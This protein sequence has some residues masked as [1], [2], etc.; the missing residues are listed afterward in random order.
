MLNF[1]NWLMNEGSD[2]GSKTGLYP[3]GY[4]GIG[5]YPPQWYITRSADAI[6]YL[7][8]DD[9]I[10]K[11][12]DSGQFDITH[13]PGDHNEKMNSGDGGLWDITRIRGKPSHLKKNSNFAANKGEG[14]PWKITH[15]PGKPTYTKHKDFI[16]DKGEGGIWN[17][18]NI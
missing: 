2:T 8:I 11:G 6:F 12:K 1:K 14:A 15:L 4:G 3:L 16:P 18:K 9:R 7:S 10:Y 13:I 5:L 17:I